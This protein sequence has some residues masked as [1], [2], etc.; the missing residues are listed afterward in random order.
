VDRRLRRC[1]E[2]ETVPYGQGVVT[3]IMGRK[4]AC[5]WIARCISPLPRLTPK[6]FLC[7]FWAAVRP[8]VLNGAATSSQDTPCQM[9]D[10]VEGISL[11]FFVSSSKRSTYQ[12]YDSITHNVSVRLRLPRRRLQRRGVYPSGCIFLLCASPPPPPAPPSDLE[13]VKEGDSDQ[14]WW[15]GP[16]LF[17]HPTLAAPLSDSAHNP[18]ICLVRIRRLHCC[19]V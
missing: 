8:C 11:C 13:C 7:I 12:D 14:H 1:A 3:I 10:R 17:L 6:I 2:A 18:L 19:A 5:S 15:P 16:A 4:A 9:N